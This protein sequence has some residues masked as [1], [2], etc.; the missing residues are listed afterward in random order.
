MWR[1]SCGC[2]AAIPIEAAAASN[3][4]RNVE[5]RNGW[6]LRMPPKTRSVG[7]TAAGEDLEAGAAQDVNTAVTTSKVAGHPAD[8]CARD[9]M[10][11]C[12]KDRR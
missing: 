11:R 10:A 12:R 2:R 7:C 6:S 1:R 3:A 4:D 9:A 5:T 8:C